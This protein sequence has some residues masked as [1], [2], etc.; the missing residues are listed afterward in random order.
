PTRAVLL[1]GFAAQAVRSAASFRE[2]FP[3]RATNPAVSL[4]QREEPPDDTRRTPSLPRLGPHRHRRRP[5]PPQRAAG[6]PLRPGGH[7]PVV[8]RGAGSALLPPSGAGKAAGQA[9]RRRRRL[10]P[11]IRPARPA[12]P[13]GCA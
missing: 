5:S 6:S 10:T 7:G 8:R 9:L 11:A 13:P 12:P 3:A 1:S 2:G 4:A